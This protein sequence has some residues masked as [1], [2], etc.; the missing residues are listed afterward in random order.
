LAVKASIDADRRPGRFVLTGSASLLRVRG[1]ADSLVG[2]VGR[3]TLFGFSQGEITGLSGR[4]PR[5]GTRAGATYRA[6]PGFRR[7]PSLAILTC[8][9]PLVC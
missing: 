3:L 2:R 9:N 5:R 7:A 1:L 4:E 8:G 6:T